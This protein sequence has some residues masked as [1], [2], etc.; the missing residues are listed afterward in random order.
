M[1]LDERTLAAEMVEVNVA[2]F[3]A[4]RVTTLAFFLKLLLQLFLLVEAKKLCNRREH[5]ALI[6]QKIY[7]FVSNFLSL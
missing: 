4:E 2:K 1:A 7:Y 3:I 6:D 5:R